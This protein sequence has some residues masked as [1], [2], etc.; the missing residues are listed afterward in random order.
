MKKTKY[1]KILIADEKPIENSFIKSMIDQIYDLYND[2]KSEEL[3]NF[4]LKNL[5]SKWLH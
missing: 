1:K 2:Q 3:K 4:L 5:S